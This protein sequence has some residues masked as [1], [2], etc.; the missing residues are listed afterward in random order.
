LLRAIDSVGLEPKV[1]GGA[2]I[3]PQNGSVKL[4]LGPALNGVVNYEYWLPAPTTMYPGVANLIAKYQARAA[5]AGSDPLGYYVVP[6][7]FAQMQVV[8]QAITGTGS[9]DDAKLA[10]F[11]RAHTFK[12]VVGDVRFGPGGGWSEPRVLFVQYQNI[13][14]H[15]ISDFTNERT[16]PVVWPSTPASGNFV[17]PYAR[18]RKRV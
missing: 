6:Q 16:Q 2:M 8:E 5:A 18:A 9:L 1:V 7:A 15:D 12:T 10:S 14:S 17:Y 11:T 4:E 13:T 3:G